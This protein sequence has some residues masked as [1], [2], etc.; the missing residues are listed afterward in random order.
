MVNQGSFREPARSFERLFEQQQLSRRTLVR[1]MAGVTLLG[2]SL[3]P[4]TTSC[5]TTPAALSSSSQTPTAPRAGTSL[6][7]YRG[8]T[9]T[10]ETVAW[11]PDGKRIASGGDDGTVQVWDAATGG[12]VFTYSGHSDRVRCAVWS[13]DGKRL[14]SGSADATAQLWDPSTARSIL[15][16]RG[17]RGAVNAVAWSP[18][19]KRLASGSDDATVQVWVAG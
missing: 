19:G 15:T 5:G 6:Y 1:T 4:L 2:G 9:S 7:T 3:I 17:H 18:D 10:V 12:H 11:S 8:H 13:P 14:V 16:Y